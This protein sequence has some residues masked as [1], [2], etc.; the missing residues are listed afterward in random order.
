MVLQ[1]FG[2]VVGVEDGVLGRLSQTL[3]AHRGNIDPGY[4]ED[5]GTAP[6]RS[7]NGPNRIFAAEIHHRMVRNAYGTHARAAASMRNAK[8]FVQIQMT[9]V[10]AHVSRPANPNLSVQVGP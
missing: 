4:G 8:R 2:D 9:H 3:A 1:P 6:G 5:A 7:R 10:R